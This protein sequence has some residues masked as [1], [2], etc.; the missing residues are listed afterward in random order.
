M[1]PS[2]ICSPPYVYLD[3]PLLVFIFEHS[4]EFFHDVI[5][6][7]CQ[8]ALTSRE[9]HL[10]SICDAEG[11]LR[12]CNVVRIANDDDIRILVLYSVCHL[13]E[14][15]DQSVVLIIL[16]HYL[17]RWGPAEICRSRILAP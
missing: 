2:K 12:W 4:V 16:N 10:V 9:H 3:L 11:V 5:K 1:I 6:R 14:E 7:R 17:L 8:F 13:D 15:V